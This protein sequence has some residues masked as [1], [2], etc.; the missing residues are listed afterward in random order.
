MSRGY[1]TY[2]EITDFGPYVTK[3]ILP[4][5][6]PVSSEAVNPSCFSVHVQR[7]TKRARFTSSPKAGPSGTALSPVRAISL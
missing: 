2:T 5:P 3:I 1:Y 6:Q 7:W 4:F